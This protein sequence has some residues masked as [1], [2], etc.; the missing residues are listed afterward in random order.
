[1]LRLAGRKSDI[2]YT[3]NKEPKVFVER[4]AAKIN[5]ALDR[6]T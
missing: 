5:R 1:M 6:H 4:E 2:H 3:S